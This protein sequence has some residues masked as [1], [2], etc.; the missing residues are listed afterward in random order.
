MK[1]NLFLTWETR[2]IVLIK[3]LRPGGEASDYKP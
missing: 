3:G 2:I 1:Q